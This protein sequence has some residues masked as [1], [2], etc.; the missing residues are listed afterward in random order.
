MVVVPVNLVVGSFF[1]YLSLVDSDPNT[2]FYGPSPKPVDG[3]ELIL[4]KKLRN[5]KQIDLILTISFILSEVFSGI[6]M[7]Y[8]F[9]EI[10]SSQIYLG[11]ESVLSYFVKRYYP[12]YIC[13]IALILIVIDYSKKKILSAIAMIAIIAMGVQRCYYTYKTY[14]DVAKEFNNPEYNSLLEMDFIKSAVLIVIIA[15]LF[16]TIFIKKDIYSK[17][18]VLFSGL[19]MLCGKIVDWNF[20][21]DRFY[22]T[23]R[24]IDYT[25]MEFIQ[26]EVELNAIFGAILILI[27]YNKRMLQKLKEEKASLPVNAVQE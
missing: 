16:G 12:L 23:R 7:A 5:R 9:N 24:I 20:M 22:D 2:N 11:E 1:L 18:L 6:L 27:V 15:V 21:L 4:D 13:I 10:A 14:V 8:L 19:L 17:Y 25:L 3:E 26:N